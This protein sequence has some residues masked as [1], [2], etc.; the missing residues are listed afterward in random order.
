MVVWGQNMGD[1][2]EVQ[3]K[4]G[5]GVNT[6]PPRRTTMVEQVLIQALTNFLCI[7][8]YSHLG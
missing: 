7:V 1:C 2:L 6:L 8:I 5:W 4:E 3:D